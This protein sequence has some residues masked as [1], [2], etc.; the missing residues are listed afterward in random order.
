MQLSETAVQT[1]M[2]PWGETAQNGIGQAFLEFCRFYTNAF[3]VALTVHPGRSQR[4]EDPVT[5]YLRD[6]GPNGTYHPVSPL[7]CSSPTRL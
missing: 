4:A 2:L 6:L 5:V 1:E 3:I 7:G